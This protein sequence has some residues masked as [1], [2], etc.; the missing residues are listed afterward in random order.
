MKYD[1]Y[2]RLE[3]LTPVHIGSGDTSDPFDYVIT[4]KNGE[5]YFCQID[6]DAW[7]EDSPDPEELS[8]ILDGGKLPVIRKYIADNLDTDIYAKSRSRIISPE[9]GKKYQ[10]HIANTNSP[11]QLL[12]DPALKNPLTGGLLIPGSSI[13]GAMRTAVID[14]CDQNW[15]LNLKNSRNQRETLERALGSIRES[16]FKQLKIGDFE[17]VNSNSAIVMAKEKSIKAEKSDGTPKNSCE[18]TF[19]VATE[20]EPQALFGRVS[21]GK[22]NL[23]QDVCLTCTMNNRTQSWSLSE[24]MQLASNFYRQRFDQE[25]SKFYDQPH[26]SFSKDVIKF[27]DEEFSSLQESQMILR[28]G[29]YSHI[30]AMTITNNKPGGK[31]GY[32]KTRTLANGIYPFGWVKLTLCSQTEHDNYW[33][34]KRQQEQ[35]LICQHQ[36][37]RQTKIDSRRQQLKDQLE[38]QQQQQQKEKERLEQ[39]QDEIDN[40]W[41]KVVRNINRID[42]WGDLKQQIL[43]KEE[44]APFRDITEFTQAVYDQVVVIR[45]TASKW[46]DERD[47]QVSQWLEPAV[48]QWQK[49]SAEVDPSKKLSEQEQ[50]EIETI[51]N[52][53][54]WGVYKT[55]HIELSALSLA[56]LKELKIKLKKWGC[57]K[58]KAKKDKQEIWE[59]VVQLSSNK[60]K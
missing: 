11:N 15:N 35:E 21:I 9:I 38:Q 22:Q 25:K 6:L 2:I 5:D 49:Q 37:L 52:M 33:Q 27:L 14:W 57:D 41:K 23:T 3:L 16:A 26:F 7:L 54:D 24:L 20:G 45:K 12:I 31:K 42:N 1:N 17:A 39:E 34:Q 48:Q 59:K 28:V 43:E 8:N 40:P 44:L 51:L 30:E 10:Q 32:G 36:R 53:K 50:A 47:E 46:S 4:S 55:S 60:K 18:I 58:K 56:A 13:K 19:S 29:R